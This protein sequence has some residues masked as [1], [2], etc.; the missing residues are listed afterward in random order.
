MNAKQVLVRLIGYRSLYMCIPIEWVRANNLTDHDLAYLT[1]VE[2]RADKF[3]VTLVKAP[4]PQELV[5]Q[6][7]ATPAE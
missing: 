4:V 7:A 6:E 5:E 3:T 1:P 2:G